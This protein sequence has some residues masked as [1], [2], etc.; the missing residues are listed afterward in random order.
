MFGFGHY[1]DINSCMMGENLLWQTEMKVQ[2]AHYQVLA[3][4]KLKH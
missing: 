3:S 1:Y 4:R 2:K